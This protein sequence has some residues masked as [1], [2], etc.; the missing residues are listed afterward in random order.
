M[1]TKIKAIKKGQIYRDRDKRSVYFD[2]S[3][4]EMK[5]RLVEVIK[6][7][8]ELTVQDGTALF[9]EVK[10]LHTGRLHRIRQ[11]RFRKFFELV[12]EPRK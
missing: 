11:D 10:S 8:L 1:A 5:Q 9:V 6:P 7:K 3:D 12:D 2:K 4:N